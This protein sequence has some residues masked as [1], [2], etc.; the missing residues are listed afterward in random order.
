MTPNNQFLRGRAVAARLAHTQEV[1]GATPTPATNLPSDPVEFLG[2]ATAIVLDVVSP[3]AF[4]VVVGVVAILLRE[5]L[6]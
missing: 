1:V 3:F 2:R 6:R 4:V 5:V